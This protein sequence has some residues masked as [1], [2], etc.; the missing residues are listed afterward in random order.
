MSDLSIKKIREM[1]AAHNDG[2]YLLG[3]RSNIGEIVDFLLNESEYYYNDEMAGDWDYLADCEDLEP[4]QILELSAARTVGK[5]YVACIENHNRLFATK[6]GAQTAIDAQAMNELR[7]NELD[8][9]VA[10][11]A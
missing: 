10:S 3:V 6:E 11:G 5:A 1:L 8:S 2:V 9:I 4:G 7:S